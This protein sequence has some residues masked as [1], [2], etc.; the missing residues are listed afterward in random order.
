MRWEWLGDDPSRLNCHNDSFLSGE[1]ITLIKTVCLYRWN[2]FLSSQRTNSCRRGK[3]FESSCLPL[4]NK[5]I[6]HIYFS[7]S[8]VRGFSSMFYY[9]YTILLHTRLVRAA[10][11]QKVSYTALYVLGG[12][13]YFFFSRWPGHNV[14]VG[15]FMEN[16]SCTH[17]CTEIVWEWRSLI[18]RSPGS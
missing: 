4:P 9:V 14:D 1:Y 6:N 2:K 17:F 11:T 10:S 16:L 7:N 8:P 12:H 3:R 15:H 5:T 18:S 13:F